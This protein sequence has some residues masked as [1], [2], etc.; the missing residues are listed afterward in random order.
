MNADTLVS[1][2]TNRELQIHGMLGTV[3]RDGDTGEIVSARA[4][5][6]TFE[7]TKHDE[8]GDDDEEEEHKKT[9]QFEKAMIE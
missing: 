8:D 4:M 2:L 1:G 6:L 9:L 3:E 5:M 7:E